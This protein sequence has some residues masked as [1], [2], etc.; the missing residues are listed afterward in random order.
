MVM[1]IL[2]GPIAISA[3]QA[4]FFAEVRAKLT[5]VDEGRRDRT[6]SRVSKYLLETLSYLSQIDLKTP[7]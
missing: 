7:H 6:Y 5:D 1:K 3:N 2:T 4:V